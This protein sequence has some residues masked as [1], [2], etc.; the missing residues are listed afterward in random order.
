MERREVMFE[1]IPEELRNTPQWV[2]WKAEMRGGRA[3]KVPYQVNGKLA[4]SNNPKT[5]S[6]FSVAVDFFKKGGYTGIGFMFSKKDAFVGIDIDHC[7][8]NG[9]LSEF[10]SKIVK[11]M[12]SYTEFSPSGKGLH[13]IVKGELEVIGTG[14][15]DAKLGLEVYQYGRYFTFTGNVQREMDV[16]F[17]DKELGVLMGRYFDGGLA[18]E[19][20][21]S[22]SQGYSQNRNQSGSQGYSQNRNQSSSQSYNQNQNRNQHGSHTQKPNQHPPPTTNRSQLV[23]RTHNTNVTNTE[24]WERMFASKN[25][26]A[27]H[28]L[29]LGDIQGDHSG[30]DM[31]L[32]NHLAFW[33]N[34][35]RSQMDSMFR[36]SNLYRAKWDKRHYADGSTYGQMTIEKAIHSTTVT[37]S[38]HFRG[39]KQNN[40]RERTYNFSQTSGV[41]H[42]VGRN[43]GEGRNNQRRDFSPAERTNNQRRD[44]LEEKTANNHRRYVSPAERTNN[45]RRDFS[46]EERTN[47]QRRDFSPEERTNN[48]RRDFSPAE[49]TNNQH[50]NV[51]LKETENQ[52]NHKKNSPSFRLSELGNAE[53]IAYYHG[54]HI[55][56]C[57]EWGWMIWNGKKWG[58]DNKQRIETIAANTLRELYNGN[59]LEKEWAKKCE[60]RNIRISSIMDTRPMVAI[61]KDK[62]D[63]HSMLLNCANGVIDLKTGE[64]L[65][66]NPQLL[67]T[68]QIKVD[69]TKEAECPKWLAFLSEIFPSE[70]TRHFLQKA[71]GYTLTGDTT[72]QVMFFLYGTGKNGKSTFINTIQHLLSDYARQAKI[73]TFVKKKYES[74]INNDIARLDGARFVSAVESEQERQLSEVLVKQITGGE[75][76]SARFLHQEFFEF[77]PICKVFFTTNHRPVIT[78]TDEGIWRRIRLIPFPMTIEKVDVKLPETLQT[79]MSG[80]L[81]WAVEGCLRWQAEGLLESEQIKQ[82]TDYYRQDMDVLDPFIK[83]IC[84][85]ESK[86]EAK[87]LYVAYQNWCLE[88][89]EKMS[90][91]RNFYRLLENRGFEKGTGSQNKSYFFGI[92]L[93]EQIT[94]ED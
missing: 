32:C 12:D 1:R 25:G 40:D 19:Q 11:Y 49:R 44:F 26:N 61:E 53:R 71:I 69:Y 54:R 14:K 5:W 79:E 4:Q 48:Q 13:I 72:E 94:E 9:V 63:T 35:D 30:A 90:T 68:K 92:S 15:R 27:I 65:P 16:Q 24:L 50:R 88:N 78:G 87:V 45:Q 38:D 3:T 70:D 7:L 28:A 20:N 84:V 82:A 43:S 29:F 77:T 10:A 58:M 17:R 39:N 67:L 31:A 59:V 51:S 57:P 74:S 42:G 86:I 41:D 47:N 8:T 66:H 23:S 21:Q 22:G 52:R 60:K 62:F 2:V 18:R 64:L 83:G 81:R 37:I 33:T 56:F 75:K 46:P 89:N 76:I 34:K 93:A 91:A 36:E 6:S 85:K 55:R 80:I 73:D